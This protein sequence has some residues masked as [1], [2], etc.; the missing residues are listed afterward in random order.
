[1]LENMYGE[2]QLVIPVCVALLGDLQ[3]TSFRCTR[4]DVNT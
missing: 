1:M 2:K 3:G 4:P